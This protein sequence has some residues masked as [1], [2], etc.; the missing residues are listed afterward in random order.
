MRYVRFTVAERT[1]DVIQAGDT[2]SASDYI[3]AHR[4]KW[5]QRTGAE[6]TVRAA[7]REEYD[8]HFDALVFDKLERMQAPRGR[9]KEA[10]DDN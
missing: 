1:L 7:T 2:W 6:V 8:A 3:E 10:T 5:A 4:Q 9:D